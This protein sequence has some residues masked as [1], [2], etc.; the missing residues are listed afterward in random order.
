MNAVVIFM[1]YPCPGQVKT[2]LGLKIGNKNVAELYKIFVALTFDLVKNFE[3]TEIYIAYSPKDRRAEILDMLPKSFK[4]FPQEGEDLG[5]RML[6]AFETCFRLGTKKVIILGSD[7]P[8]LPL[9]FIEEAITQLEDNDLVLGPC[10]DG[11]YYLIGL[12][13]IYAGLFKNVQ[14][15]SSTVLV[16]T[17]QR[18]CEMKIKY[19]LLPVWYDVDDIK[20][21]LRSAEDDK[22]NRIKKFINQS[23]DGLQVP[24]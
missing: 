1:K 6:A 2:R 24:Q 7:S 23:L 5:Q 3:N 20:F 21:L 4:H 17:I 8:T 14:W 18:A 16:T 11:G 9:K 22:S 10:E 12:K 19:S 15:S 13:K